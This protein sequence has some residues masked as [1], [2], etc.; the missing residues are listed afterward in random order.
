MPITISQ[1][2]VN[3]L[4][5]ALNMDHLVEIMDRDYTDPGINQD[6]SREK[7]S[8]YAKRNRSSIRI[9]TGR[10]YIIE[11]HAHRIERAKR[12]KLP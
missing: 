6:V 10:F 1:K 12:L 11:E 7:A 3:V 2:T 4:L 9:N 8:R 5:K